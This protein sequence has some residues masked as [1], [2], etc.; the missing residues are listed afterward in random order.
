MTTPR[1]SPERTAGRDDAAR[2]IETMIARYQADHDNARDKVMRAGLARH[3]EHLTEAAKIARRGPTLDTAAPAPQGTAGDELVWARRLSGHTTP[4]LHR[5][6]P[7]QILKCRTPGHTDYQVAYTDVDDAGPD[8]AYGT[9]Y[10]TVRKVR[11]YDRR[12][13]QRI[14]TGEYL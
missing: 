5:L 13:K 10:T 3:I 4:D 7:G 2:D 12:L 1:T 9:A 14:A 6:K 8:H 11:W